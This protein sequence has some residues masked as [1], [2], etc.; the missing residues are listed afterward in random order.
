MYHCRVL[1]LSKFIFGI[2]KEVSST[3]LGK[4]GVKLSCI[5]H[6]W[7]QAGCQR[8][9]LTKTAYA[10]VPCSRNIL[11]LLASEGSRSE[12]ITSRC[13][14]SAALNS[15]CRPCPLMPTHLLL[16]LSSVYS[17]SNKCPVVISESAKTL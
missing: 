2:L 12:S 16:G 13:L 4:L 5:A 15:R 3:P 7:L 9:Y 11:L 8:Q 14:L 10:K 1:S 6:G 17:V